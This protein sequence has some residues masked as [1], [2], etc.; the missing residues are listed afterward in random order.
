MVRASIFIFILL[1]VISASVFVYVLFSSGE[2]FAWLGSG[3]CI[4]VAVAETLDMI[5]EHFYY[6][7][8]HNY[9]GS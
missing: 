6:R 8:F 4:G 9:R 3:M 7:K 2:W 1:W 5:R